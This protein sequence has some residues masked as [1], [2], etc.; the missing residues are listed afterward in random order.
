MIRDILQLHKKLVVFIVSA[1]LT[2]CV[3][4]PTTAQKQKYYD[5]CKMATKK[6]TVEPKVRSRFKVCDGQGLKEEPLA[7]MV[8]SGLVGSATYIVS[9]SV[10]VIGNTIHWLEY[11]AGCTPKEKKKS[12]WITT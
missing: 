12:N 1:I 10:V 2:S 5:K 8:L 9:G 11:K 7:C 3:F 6:L 4:V